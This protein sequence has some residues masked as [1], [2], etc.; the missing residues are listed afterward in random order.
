MKLQDR[1]AI[2]TGGAQGIGKAICRRLAQD[3]AQLAI[4]DIKLDIAQ[5]TASEF[6]A[7]GV[8]A[9]AYQ[10]NVVNYAEVEEMVK[11][12]GA[13]F[14]R[15]DIL[16]NN[17]GIT[18]DDLIMRMKEDAWDM[19][20]A[21]NLKGTFNCTKAVCRPMMKARYGKIVNIASIVGVMGNPGQ[22][23]YSA[24]KAGVIG[25]TK[26]TAKE[27][28]A[29]N[30]TANA[31]APGYIQTEMTAHLSDEQK[32]IFLNNTPLQRA[33]TPED[34]ANVVAFL[35]GPD[36]DYVTGQVIHIDGGMVM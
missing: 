33:G 7:Q 16:V 27:L 19:V 13:D 2:V 24:S 17:A 28:A 34:V 18:R 15:I 6:V 9:R 1:V 12:V 30:V 20:I 3:G 35:A 8:T 32:G 4:V 23:N 5:A 10:A 14:G 36:S 31:V 11:Q 26:S 22:A 21:V 25:L 29:R